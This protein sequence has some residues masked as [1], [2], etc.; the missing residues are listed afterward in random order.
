[1]TKPKRHKL[2]ELRRQL[3][4]SQDQMARY[5]GISVSH[6]RQIETGYRTPSLD[7][8]AKIAHMLGRTVDELFVVDEAGDCK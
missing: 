4:K 7:L 6:W 5:V 8:A 2:I 1:M 3:G